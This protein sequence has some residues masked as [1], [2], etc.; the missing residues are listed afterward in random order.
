LAGWLAASILAATVATVTYGLVSGAG[1]LLFICTIGFAANYFGTIIPRS[2]GLPGSLLFVTITGNLG[3]L[4]S[5]YALKILFPQAINVETIVLLYSCAFMAPLI[6]SQGLRPFLKLN[7]PRYS[8]LLSHMATEKSEYGAQLAQ[9]VSQ[10]LVTNADLLVLSL[11]AQPEEVGQY[12]VAKTLF[13]M[14]LMPVSAI[15]YMLLPQAVAREGGQAGTHPRSLFAVGVV[16]VF[17]SSALLFVVSTLIVP[18]LYGP[19][20]ETAASAARLGA[21]GAAFYGVSLLRS[22][23]WMAWRKTALFGLLVA[24]TSA[25]DLMVLGVIPYTSTA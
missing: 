4:L 22:A 15:F 17:L 7:V 14:V 8:D 25:A 23:Y 12:A 2:F 19:A 3:Q 18:V 9:Q 16:L 24:S 11:L 6:L 1:A 21:V 13:M 10:L 5:L 20:Y